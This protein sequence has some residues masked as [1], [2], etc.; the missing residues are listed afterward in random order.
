MLIIAQE[1]CL[2]CG[3]C[4]PLCP[5]EGLFLSFEDLFCDQALC[6]LCGAC[7]EFCPVRAITL[8]LKDAV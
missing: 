7:P 1:L 6:T 8:E 2:D 3:G 4:V 5:V